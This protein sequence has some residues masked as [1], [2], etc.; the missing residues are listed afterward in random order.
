MQ[1]APS[2]RLSV[3]LFPLKLLNRV[4]FDPEL[5]YVMGHHHSYTGIEEGK[6]SVSILYKRFTNS[7]KLNNYIIRTFKKLAVNFKLTV[8]EQGIKTR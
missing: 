1:S 2:V 6:K 8:T 3:R 4:T 7:L 5:L